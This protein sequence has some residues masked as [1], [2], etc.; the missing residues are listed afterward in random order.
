MSYYIG[1]AKKRGIT[2]FIWDNGAKEEFGLLDRSSNT[3]Y[4]K[5]IVEAAVKAAG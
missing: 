3:W 2:C 4:F 1:S 5:N